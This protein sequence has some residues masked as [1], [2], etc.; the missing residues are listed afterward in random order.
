ME[1]N[2]IRLLRQILDRELVL[3]REL[4]AMARLR[5]ILL[6]Q[7][8]IDDLRAL[9]P[10]EARK[11]AEVRHLEEMRGTL[12]PQIHDRVAPPD[13]AEATRRIGALIRRIGAVERA[14]WALLA[15]HAVRVAS[16]DR[17]LAVWTPV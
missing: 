2:T 4:L 1:H 16:A 3:H 10:A 9:Y 14:S 5:H 12:A 8:R 15:R 13:L 11:V 6:C 17:G 7:G